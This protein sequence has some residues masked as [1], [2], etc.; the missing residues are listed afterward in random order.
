MGL[1]NSIVKVYTTLLNPGYNAP[2][3]SAATTTGTGS[4]FIVSYKDKMF[5]ITNAHVVNLDTYVQVKLADADYSTKYEAKVLTIGRDCDLA[6]LEVADPAFQATVEPLKFTT[7]RQ[8]TGDKARVVGFPIGGEECCQTEG[9]ISRS[10]RVQYAFSKCNLLT[11][12]IDA[13]ISPGNS[14]GPVLN[15]DGQVVGVVHQSSL[16]GRTLGQMIP[17]DIIFHFLDDA[18]NNLRYAGFPDFDAI[19]QEMENPSLR[20]HL[21]M[22][23][24]QTGILVNTVPELSSAQGLLQAGDVLLSVDGLLINNTGKVSLKSEFETLI[25]FMCIVQRH[26]VGDV[27]NFTVLRDK[28]E[29]KVAVPLTRSLLEINDLIPFK[30]DEATPAYIE[31]SGI[32][33]QPLTRNYINSWSDVN[34][35][36]K[37]PVSLSRYVLQSSLLKTKEC[38]QIVL[39]R[40]ILQN[41]ETNG[42][43]SFAGSSIV[44]EINQRKITN[45]WA[46][47]HALDSNEAAE[48]V[49]RTA[50]DKL[51]VVKNLKPEENEALRNKYQMT[52]QTAPQYADAKRWTLFMGKL[53]EKKKQ[54][55]FNDAKLERNRIRLQPDAQEPV[56]ETTLVHVTGLK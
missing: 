47:W 53:Q 33:L 9:V 35:A 28:Q 5:L 1:Y 21:G 7:S 6:I 18:I 43:S 20:S 31:H 26:H 13:K 29:I 36:Y 8:K 41:N 16:D 15:I 38:K 37:G 51:I 12:S 22:G 34:G 56:D 10:D 11:T 2:W 17:L 3:R 48:H 49:I 25:D 4:G 27:V 19:T 42:Y 14:G 55:R 50:E 46:A 52:T 54:Q 24:G 32:V 44:Q 40:N 30:L 45:L 23:T 39:I